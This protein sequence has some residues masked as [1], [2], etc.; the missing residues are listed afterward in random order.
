MA[1]NNN[2]ELTPKGSS[3]SAPDNW[4]CDYCS[5]INKAY[6]YK[7]QGIAYRFNF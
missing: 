7:C 1:P 3:S 2:K 6:E 4:I 5:F